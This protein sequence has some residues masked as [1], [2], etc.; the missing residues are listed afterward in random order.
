MSVFRKGGVAFDVDAV[1]DAAASF[2]KGVLAVSLFGA[3]GATTDAEWTTLMANVF[4]AA[5]TPGWTATSRN[6]VRGFFEK[7]VNL[8]PVR[9]TP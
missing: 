1:R 7:L 3:N 8:R 2:A 5:N 6:F 9:T 4:S